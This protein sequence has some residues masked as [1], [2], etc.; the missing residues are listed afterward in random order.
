[1]N[2]IQFRV[3]YLII[4]SLLQLYDVM[5]RYVVAGKAGCPSFARAELLAD[6]LSLNLPDFKV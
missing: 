5:A 3:F 1:M 6:D 2:W 4:N